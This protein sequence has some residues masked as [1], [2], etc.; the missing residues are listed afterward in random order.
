MYSKARVQLGLLSPTARVN[1][2]FLERGDE[3]LGDGIVVAGA[4]A[5]RRS[6]DADPSIS[7]V[8][9]SSVDLVHRVKS[10]LVR[11]PLTG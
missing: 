8:E 1:E 9:D 10:L 6:G 11:E 3:A 7:P 5:A 2:L 4:L